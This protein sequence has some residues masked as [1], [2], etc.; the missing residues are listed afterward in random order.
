MHNN[1]K[2]KKPKREKQ[3]VEDAL[4]EADAESQREAV[5]KEVT[6]HD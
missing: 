6:S 5:A 2:S 3:L 4:Q 1:T